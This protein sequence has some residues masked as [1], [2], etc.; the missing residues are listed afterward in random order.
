MICQKT[1]KQRKK[2]RNKYPVKRNVQK[3]R[4]KC[5]HFQFL[6]C[7]NHPWMWPF[8]PR[9]SLWVL[10]ALQYPDLTQNWNLLLDH[11][12]P[13]EGLSCPGS[14]LWLLFAGGGRW[15]K[16]PSSSPSQDKPGWSQKLE[17]KWECSVKWNTEGKLP[18]RFT[19][20]SLFLYMYTCN[21]NRWVKLFFIISE[22]AQIHVHLIKCSIS[23][24]VFHPFHKVR[25]I[26]H[27]DLLHRDVFQPFI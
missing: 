13:P 9:F 20:T 25:L 7:W 26:F 27:I 18:N 17:E 2:N 14:Q 16:P 5:W 12:C 3:W 10:F 24:K 19:E 6:E 23:K 11:R 4:K 1:W 21:K 22:Q 8:D 15:R